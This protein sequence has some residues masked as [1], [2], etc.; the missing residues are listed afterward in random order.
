MTPR[1][2]ST[3]NTNA[4]PLHAIPS[5]L[6]RTCIRHIYLHICCTRVCLL[7]TLGD[8]EHSVYL[9]EKYIGAFQQ[10][11]S[12]DTIFKACRSV[13]QK[14]SY[15]LPWWWCVSHFENLIPIRHILNASVD[16]RRRF[17]SVVRGLL[18]RFNLNKSANFSLYYNTHFIRA[19][20]FNIS[21]RRCSFCSSD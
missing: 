2:V 8:Q 13:H 4:V 12:R 14:G 7:T 9:T 20:K 1:P 18:L 21:W 3:H 17:Q 5:D 6:M 11:N 15:G 16:N 19:G 10:R